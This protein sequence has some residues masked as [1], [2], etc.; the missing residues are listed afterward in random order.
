MQDNA[1]ANK[2]AY[3]ASNITS[4]QVELREFRQTFSAENV[5]AAKP[6]IVM[7]VQK[8][9]DHFAEQLTRLKLADARPSFT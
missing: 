6:R 8:H 3:C 1:D 4:S 5:S 7:A 9:E 2:R